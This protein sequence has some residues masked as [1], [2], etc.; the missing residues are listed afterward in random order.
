M[1]TTWAVKGTAL[2]AKSAIY[3]P[4]YKLIEV[5]DE[6]T[7]DIDEE[8]DLLM[9]EAVRDHYGFRLFNASLGS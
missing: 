2:K 3:V 1:G 4:P 7:E 6:R 5:P 8:F 9:A